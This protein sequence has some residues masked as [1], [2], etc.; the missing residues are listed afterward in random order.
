MCKFLL[1]IINYETG[2]YRLNYIL[3]QKQTKLLL[4]TIHR[5]NTHKYKLDYIIHTLEMIKKI[6]QN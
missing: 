4:F 2:N 5:Y 1:D 3:H 6:T